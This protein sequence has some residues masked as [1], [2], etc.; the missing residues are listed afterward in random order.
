LQRTDLTAS[1][2]EPVWTTRRTD[3]RPISESEIG[4][5]T[6]KTAELLNQAEGVIYEDIRLFPKDIP[7]SWTIFSPYIK[8][9]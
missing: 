1:D 5:T 6:K 9:A 4:W 7:R 2:S 8:R 3:L